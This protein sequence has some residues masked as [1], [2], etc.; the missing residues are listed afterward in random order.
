[1]RKERAAT[2]S[3]VR[4]DVR[5]DV[6]DAS[7]AALSRSETPD[8]SDVTLHYCVSIASVWKRNVR[9]KEGKED[10]RMYQMRN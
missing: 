8:V 2:H 3:D 6:R 1:M 7:A 4:R 5:R 9:D 10:P